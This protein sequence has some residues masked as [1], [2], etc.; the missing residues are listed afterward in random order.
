MTETASR[1]Q[2]VL[3]LPHSLRSLSTLGFEFMKCLARCLLWRDHVISCLLQEEIQSLKQGQVRAREPAKPQ[4][5]TY[6]AFRF[7]ASQLGPSR[8]V[9]SVREISTEE[10]VRHHWGILAG[11]MPCVPADSQ[12]LAGCI[13]RQLL[14]LGGCLRHS[15]E[16]MPC[17]EQAIRCR[18]LLAGAL[19]SLSLPARMC[20][21][22]FRG[23]SAGSP[24]CSKSAVGQ[25]APRPNLMKLSAYFA[26][27]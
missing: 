26:C 12:I 14:L 2:A 17:K 13:D 4:Q 21:G 24:V 6:S 3:R 9:G 16:S 10:Q 1:L 20:L 7:G 15:A 5:Q 19:T 11:Q 22:L 23:V 27:I 25:P 8:L 18:R